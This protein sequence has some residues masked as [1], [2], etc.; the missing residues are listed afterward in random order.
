MKASGALDKTTALLGKD[1]A[2]VFD[3]IPPNPPLSVMEEG[4]AAAKESGC[5]LIVAIGGGSAIDSAKAMALIAAHDSPAVE[6]FER[7][8]VFSAPG[9]PVIAIPTTA[10]TGSEVNAFMVATA[11]D[12]DSK[13]ACG[14]PQA[15]PKTAILDPELS[16]SLPKNQTASTGLDALSHAVEAYWTKNFQ[17]VSDINALES[18]RLILRWLPAAVSDGADIEARS[19]MLLASMLASLAFG[20]TGTGGPHG[21]SYPLTVRWNLD[22]GLAVAFTLPEF[23]ERNLP[24]LGKQ[25]AERLSDALGADSPGE[26]IGV[27]RSFCESMGAPRSLGD[28]GIGKSDISSVVALSS[29]INLDN[30]PSPITDKEVENILLKK[31]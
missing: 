11:P 9:L 10:G 28:I 21:V 8:K 23:L 13:I 25:R 26:S 4:A 22:H 24:L 31:L 27:L 1:G 18:I 15:F 2:V 17:P 16:I 29:R 12:R 14:P 5:R 7:R 19:N 6:Y 3:K 20:S 30:S